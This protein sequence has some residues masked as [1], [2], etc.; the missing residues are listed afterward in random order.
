MVV[1]GEIGLVNF[2]PTVKSEFL[3]AYDLTIDPAH[4]LF[5]LDDT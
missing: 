1:R 3:S 5:V 2:D 4:N